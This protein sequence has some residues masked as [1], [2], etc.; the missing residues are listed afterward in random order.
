MKTVISCKINN[1]IRN[2][3]KNFLSYLYKQNGW[4]RAVFETCKEIYIPSE[5]CC[6]EIRILIS[7]SGDVSIT[8]YSLFDI[9]KALD[10]IKEQFEYGRMGYY[11]V[12]DEETEIKLTF[13]TSIDMKEYFFDEKETLTTSYGKIEMYKQMATLTYD[14]W[15]NGK[16][17]IEL[18]YS[19]LH[20]NDTVEDEDIN[21]SKENKK[22]NTQNEK[23]L[24]SLLFIYSLVRLAQ[25]L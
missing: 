3:C 14:K 12:M 7:N 11:L 15:E 1:F 21:F 5:T 19:A 2:Y 6:D 18:F 16:D 22:D 4:R 8:A 10:F 24:L 9:L 23:I 25:L 20:E 13:T 17:L